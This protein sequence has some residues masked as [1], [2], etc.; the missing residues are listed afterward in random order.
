MSDDQ[1]VQNCFVSNRENARYDRIRLFEPKGERLKQAE[2]G[3]KLAMRLLQDPTGASHRH[4]YRK[5]T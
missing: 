1:E 2:L 5:Q 3:L 4:R